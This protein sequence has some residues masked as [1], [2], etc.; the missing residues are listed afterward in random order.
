MIERATLKS[1]TE[2]IERFIA[3]TGAFVG[4]AATAWLT[5]LVT[6][7]ATLPLI[8]APMGASAVLLFAV[9]Q[10]PLARPWSVIGGNTL[11]ALVGVAAM[12]L[13]GPIST[14]LAAAV[15]VAAAIAVMSAARC[16][17]P[18]GGAAALTAVVGGPAIHAHGF[19]FALLPVALSSTLLV[20][21]AILYN[22]LARRRVPE[23]LVSEDP[24]PAPEVD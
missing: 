5:H 15:A 13:C 11:S 21:S 2:I 9:P 4:I 16:L 22:Y 24:E 17:H 23:A 3:P 6:D 19:T 1:P 14:V 20:S 18:P 12:M 8:V 10:S 7:D